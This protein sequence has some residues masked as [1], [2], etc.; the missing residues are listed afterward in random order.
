MRFGQKL[1]ELDVGKADTAEEVDRG[2][3]RKVWWV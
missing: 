3:G 1:R 2:K